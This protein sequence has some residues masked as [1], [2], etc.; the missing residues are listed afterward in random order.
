MTHDNNNGWKIPQEKEASFSW[1][2]PPPLFPPASISTRNEVKTPVD[3]TNLTR[4]RGTKDT[5]SISWPQAASKNTI[6][7]YTYICGP[8]QQG[9][10]LLNPTTGAPKVQG[11]ASINPEPLA[12]NSIK[13]SISPSNP[14]SNLCHEHRKSEKQTN[15]IQCDFIDSGDTDWLSHTSQHKFSSVSTTTSSRSDLSTYQKHLGTISVKDRLSNVHAKKAAAEIK[16]R[17]AMIAKKK[18]LK[19]QLSATHSIDADCK[20]TP[21]ICNT[22]GTTANPSLARQPKLLPPLPRQTMKV[23]RQDLVQRKKEVECKK[24]VE[25]VRRINILRHHIFKQERLKVDQSLIAQQ[26]TLD[27]AAC[28]AELKDA[29]DQLKTIKVNIRTLQVRKQILEE[30]TS[31]KT[32]ELVKKR[33]N[34]HDYKLTKQTLSLPKSS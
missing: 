23:K 20:T 14:P 34:L 21:K 10:S 12:R 5:L 13:Y 27:L 11:I 15:S 9:K 2:L 1:S 29:S 30:L 8:Q 32:M 3:G 22:D 4:T 17:K 25:N 26:T 16:L 6:V 18:A 31:K 33:K 19:M 24:E 28:H 7:S